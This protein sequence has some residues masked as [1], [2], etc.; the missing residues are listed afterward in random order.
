MTKSLAAS[1]QTPI[2]HDYGTCDRTCAELRIYPSALR[3]EDITLY[4]G[5]QPTDCQ[6]QGDERRNS[7]GRVRVAKCTMWSLSSE[8][9]VT[10][11]DVRAH[12]DW[13]L[14]RVSNCADAIKQLQQAHEIKMSMSCPW[15]SRGGHGGPTLWPEQMRRLADLNLECSF[16]V[17]FYPDDDSESDGQ[18]SATF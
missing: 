14:E 1:R 18:G 17:Q 6:N 8:S 13:L 10:S 7:E 16:D 15:W 9:S 12:L 4:L 5:I 11:K 2:N 3:H